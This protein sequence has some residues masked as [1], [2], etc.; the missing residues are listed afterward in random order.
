MG[1]KRDWESAHSKIAGEVCRI[2]HQGPVDPAH[3]IPRSRVRPGIGENQ[4]NIVP[5]CRFHHDLYDNGD[6][7]LLPYLTRTEQATAV[8][9]VGLAEAHRTI[10]NAGHNPHHAVRVDRLD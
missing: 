8:F 5:L 9:L 1:L 4:D 6:L 7:D 2:C 3:I 10:T